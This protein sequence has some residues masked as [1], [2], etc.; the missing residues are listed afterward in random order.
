[1]QRYYVPMLSHDE[2]HLHFSINHLR[3]TAERHI[4]LGESIGVNALGKGLL[5]FSSNKY[6]GGG[7]ANVVAEVLPVLGFEGGD[8]G[9]DLV[10][11]GDTVD[12][13]VFGNVPDEADRVLE[14]SNDGCDLS[15]V[16]FNG[17][18]VFDSSVTIFGDAGDV[19][20]TVEFAED[21]VVRAVDV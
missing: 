12:D 18:T 16:L 9:N 20:D 3:S 11:D 6:L 14:G 17:R 10:V 4:S 13:E 7:L 15:K 8:G 5:S 21:A 2:Q 19:L 1:M